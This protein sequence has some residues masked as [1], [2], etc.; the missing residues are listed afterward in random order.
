LDDPVEKFLP[1]KIRP[2]GEPIR[3]WHLLS[4]TAGIPA[5]AY[6]EAEL[7]WEQGTG[8]KPLALATVEDFVA[9]LNGATDWVEAR[10]GER[11]F[12]L[13]E[14]Y[15]LLGG[16]IEKLSGLSYADYVRKKIL[17]PLGMTEHRIFGRGGAGACHSLCGAA[18]GPAASWKNSAHSHRKRWGF[19][20]H[21][22]GFGQVFGDVASPRRA[23]SEREKL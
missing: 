3:I 13:N 19:G 6:A 10:P 15:I 16:I 17:E 9:W 1:L 18:G 23:P 20:E 21:R 5:L 8:G 4:H 7:R 12:Y 11:W 2:F 22:F 14:G